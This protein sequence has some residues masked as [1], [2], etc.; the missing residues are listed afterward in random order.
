MLWFKKH[1]INNTDGSTTPRRRNKLQLLIINNYEKIIKR[2]M[3]GEISKKD[4]NNFIRIATNHFKELKK[5][6][7]LSYHI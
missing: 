4:Y 3:M 7:L 6:G 1:K 2:Y 5:A